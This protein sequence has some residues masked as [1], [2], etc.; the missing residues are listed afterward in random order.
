MQNHL[1]GLRPLWSDRSTREPGVC[2]GS[3]ERPAVRT[4]QPVRRGL[5][6]RVL[7]PRGGEARRTGAPAAAEPGS[8]E[9]GRV[10]DWVARFV[11]WRSTFRVAALATW[12]PVKSRRYRY[13]A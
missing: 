10:G 5:L 6:V 12:S 2:R 3:N 4:M 7:A 13:S 11:R 9:T 8:A 1:R